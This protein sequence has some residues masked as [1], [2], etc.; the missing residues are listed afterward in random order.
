MARIKL[1]LLLAVCG[2]ASAQWTPQN[3]VAAAERRPDGVLFQ[4]KTGFL[5]IEVCSDSILRVIYSLER[6]VPKRPELVISRHDWPQTNWS[7]RQ[8]P[9]SYVLALARVTVTVNRAD[10]TLT[11]TDW[12]GAVLL[13]EG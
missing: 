9:E 12:S 3:R 2:I 11:Y 10:G 5:K 8:N 6:A 13:H 7:F 4:L 1:G